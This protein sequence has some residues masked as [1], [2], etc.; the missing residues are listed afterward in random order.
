MIARSREERE[1]LAKA[2][3]GFLIFELVLI[4]LFLIGLLTATE[5]QMNAAHL[6]LDH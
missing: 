4:A 1:L 2:D 3:N 5:V 6:L